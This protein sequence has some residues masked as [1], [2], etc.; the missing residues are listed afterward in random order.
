MISESVN[1]EL[2]GYGREQLCSD[3]SYC[4]SNRVE[5]LG[6]SIRNLIF[7]WDLELSHLEY[8]SGRW[9]TQE[10]CLRWGFIGFSWGQMAERKGIWRCYHPSQGFHS[11]CK[12]VKPVLVLGCPVS[13]L[14]RPGNTPQLWDPLRRPGAGLEHP[15]PPRYATASGV[16]QLEQSCSA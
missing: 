3:M 16:L 9:C 8:T 11:I 5:G 14:H 2:G 4:H 13:I 12:W 7:S 10:F 6:K 15:P 1:N